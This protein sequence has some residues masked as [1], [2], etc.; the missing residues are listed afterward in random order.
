MEV[1]ILEMDKNYVKITVTGED[2]SFLTLLQRNLLEDNR[3]E[4]AKYT[5]SHPLVGAP[6]LYVRTKNK[7]P[8]EVLKEANEDI[9]KDCKDILS[10]LSQ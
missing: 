1:K 7:D 10:A 2:D 5:I 3:V 6:I 8:L 4:V 9:A